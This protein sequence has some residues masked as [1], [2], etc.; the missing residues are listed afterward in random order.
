VTEKC[1]NLKR[2]VCPFE[3]SYRHL[4]VTPR[5]DS[6]LRVLGFM[7]AANDFQNSTGNAEG[8]IKISIG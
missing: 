5:H 7:I 8:N 1:E 2:A 6:I 3:A 4:L